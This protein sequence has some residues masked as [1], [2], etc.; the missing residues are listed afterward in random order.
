[1]SADPLPV[2]V[3]TENPA[4][5][6]ARTV[7]VIVPLVFVAFDVPAYQAQPTLLP[8]GAE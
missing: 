4:E 6:L 8:E 1:V 2:K 3:T 7:L 5:M